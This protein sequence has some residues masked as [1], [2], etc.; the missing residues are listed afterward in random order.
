MKNSAL[1]KIAARNERLAKVHYNTT[2]GTWRKSE[3]IAKVRKEVS[4][5]A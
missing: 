2:G 3:V 1:L 4:A 5:K